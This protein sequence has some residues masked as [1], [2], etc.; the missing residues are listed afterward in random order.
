MTEKTQYNKLFGSLSLYMVMFTIV[1]M[2]LISF[3]KNPSIVL[4]ITV[5]TSFLVIYFSMGKENFIKELTEKRET[6]SLLMLLFF[7]FAPM[8]TNVLGGLLSEGVNKVLTLGGLGFVDTGAEMAKEVATSPSFFLAL[9]TCLLAPL[10]EELVFRN[11]LLRGMEKPRP[12]LAVVLSGVMFA[13][14]HTN[15]D[16]SIG[17]LFT[18]I[19]FSYLGMRYS[20]WVPILVHIGNNTIFYLA[21]LF[22]SGDGTVMQTVLIGMSLFGIISGVIVLVSALK[23]YRKR[24][25]LR[26]GEKPRYLSNAFFWMY[27]VL[28]GILIVL[29]DYV[30]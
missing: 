27:F 25:D 1:P 20:M 26:Q 14:M 23:Y 16:Q 12:W 3:V 18:A 21:S 6:P 15:L 11:Y 7:I 29:N 2:L 19:Y 24:G 10:F 30:L 4:S 28:C 17:L 22:P 5:F 13:L 8:A 9:Y